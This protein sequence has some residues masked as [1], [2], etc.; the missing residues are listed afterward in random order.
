MSF[1]NNLGKPHLTAIGSGKGGTGKTLIAVSLAHALAY[2]GERVLLCDADFELSNT[3]VHLGLDDCGDL[4][5]FLANECRL[6]EAIAPVLGG[7]G[8]HGGFDII[9][10]PSGCGTLA[11][12][13]EI[14]AQQLLGKLKAAKNY[15]RVLLD[16]GAG[17][18]AGVLRFAASS[19]DALVV[20]TPDPA[21][22]TDAY[23]F[24]KLLQ[25]MTRNRVPQILVNMAVNDSE[26]RRTADALIATCKNFL[27]STPDYL[28]AI[29]HDPNALDAVRKQ[30]A[31]LTLHP[32]SASARAVTAI[33]QRLHNRLRPGSAPLRLA[34]AR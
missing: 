9:A 3:S 6:E 14:G 5:G 33:A 11:N 1:N 13:G 4:P 24:V 31:L 20:L 28:G 8:I 12:S 18:D 23:A 34:S 27:N 22:L 19:D 29:P 32:Q 2:E 17:V 10:A 30:A 16:L 7:A 21:S 25:Q 15:D 26:A